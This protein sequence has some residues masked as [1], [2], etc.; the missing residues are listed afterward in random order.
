MT[1]LFR[2]TLMGA[3]LSV[4]LTGIALA[5]DEMA[6]PHPDAMATVVC[7]TAHAGETPTATLVADKTALVCKPVA[8]MM[9]SKPKMDKSMTAQQAED[10]WNTW[11][12]NVFAISPFQ[13]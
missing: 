12:N 11:T 1:N 4:P 7:R 13:K 2:A 8:A 5:A 9:K 6:G 3:L 10:A